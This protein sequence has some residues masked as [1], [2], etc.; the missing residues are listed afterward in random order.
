MVGLVFAMQ[1][2]GLIV[3]PLLASAFLASRLCNNPVVLITVPSD[4]VVSG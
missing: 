4:S 1:G 2:A 3:G